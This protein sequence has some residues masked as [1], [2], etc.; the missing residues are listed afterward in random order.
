MQV[1]YSKRQQYIYPEAKEPITRIP[2][3]LPWSLFCKNNKRE[4]K[5]I[6]HEEW[7]RLRG[8]P[9]FSFPKFDKPPLI[10]FS[11]A[12]PLRTY[13]NASLKRRAQEYGPPRL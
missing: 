3:T 7:Q 4:I 13:V 12:P 11:K 8:F 9:D 1:S 10:V 6:L 2:F 5:N